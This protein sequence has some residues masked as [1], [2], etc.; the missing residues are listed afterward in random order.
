[1]DNSRKTTAFSAHLSWAAMR[2]FLQEKLSPEASQQVELHL[3]HCPRCSSAIIDYIQA[4]EPQHYK[5]YMKKLK[6]NLTS[7]QTAKKRFFSAFQLKAI[8]TTTAVV[9][10]LIF[11]FFAFRTVIS[12]KDTE[13]PL[14]SESLAVMKQSSSVATTRRKASS[15]VAQPSA[16]ATVASQKAPA[17]KKAVEKKPVV[18]K[19]V[20]QKNV[21]PAAKTV[22]VPKKKNVAPETRSAQPVATPR[23]AEPVEKAS[24][25]QLEAQTPTAA[26]APEATDPSPKSEE[27]AATEEPTPEVVKAKPIPTLKKLDAKESAQS[28]APLGNSRPAIIPVPGNQ[29]RE[30]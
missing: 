19:E 10:L 13:R 27:N 5:Q 12:Q 8:R 29:I 14:P 6:G 20:E 24:E 11:S 17:K 28:V 3:Q 18:K 9:A 22:V 2:R 15:G 21:Q 26:T 1:M 25:K 16:A 4:E 30:R 7:S 23:V